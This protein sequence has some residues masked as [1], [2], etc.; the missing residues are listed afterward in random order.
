M[1]FPMTIPVSVEQRREFYPIDI[2]CRDCRSSVKG[3]THVELPSGQKLCFKCFRLLEPVP[4]NRRVTQRRTDHDTTGKEHRKTDK[5]IPAQASV[6]FPNHRV[7]QRRTIFDPRG[8][9]LRRA[10]RERRKNG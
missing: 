10:G 7:A 9:Q 8:G 4:T 2:Y 5:T 6:A 1:V 3:S